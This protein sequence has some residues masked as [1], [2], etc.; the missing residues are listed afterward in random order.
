MLA[1][2][3]CLNTTKKPQLS[4]GV[5]ELIAISQGTS[6]L[7][8]YASACWLE[9][10]GDL[11]HLAQLAAFRGHN[12]M[13]IFRGDINERSD[14][15]RNVGQSVNS[16]D[17]A[18]EREVGDTDKNTTGAIYHSKKLAL[19]KLLGH[20]DFY[21]VLWVEWKDGIA[22]RKALGRVYKEAWEAQTFEEIDVILG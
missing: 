7:K 8:T 18:A 20:Y 21:N 6:D 10:T 2:A 22:Y 12:V 13:F 14:K 5:F 11:E 15:L 4:T 1:G 3:L 19:Q 16:T 17:G 9:E